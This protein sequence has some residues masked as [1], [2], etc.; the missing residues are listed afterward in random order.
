MEHGGAVD[1]DERSGIHT[2]HMRARNNNWD[3]SIGLF[4]DVWFD[5]I[6]RLTDDDEED[7]GQNT[8]W[9]WRRW[10][11]IYSFKLSWSHRV[12]VCTNLYEVDGVSTVH[13]ITPIGHLLDY[14]QAK[15][16]GR[17][18]DFGHFSPSVPS[19][20]HILLCQL[21]KLDWKYA[22]SAAFSLAPLYFRASLTKLVN[23]GECPDRPG[24]RKARN[25]AGS[26]HF[27]LIEGLLLLT[28]V[29]TRPLLKETLDW[30]KVTFR[31]T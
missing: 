24:C 14:Q 18:D 19:F 1:K 27:K 4:S 6:D 16:T 20:I 17:Q 15:E 31:C 11:S 7:Y 5:L 23:E 10:R 8:Q 28:R 12:S 22:K 3:R 9:D 30:Q 2:V 13:S 26:S 21:V 25:W 29:N